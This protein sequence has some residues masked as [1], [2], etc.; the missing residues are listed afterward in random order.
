MP[1]KFEV[2]W[3]KLDRDIVKKQ[4]SRVYLRGISPKKLPNH[5][6]LGNW[7][8][9]KLGLGSIFIAQVVAYDHILK[10]P[11]AFGC[12]LYGSPIVAISFLADIRPKMNILKP[13]K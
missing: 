8:F 12:I 1:T 3:L 9:L 5:P 4:A 7:H 6:M 2:K 13:Q 10:E 11:G